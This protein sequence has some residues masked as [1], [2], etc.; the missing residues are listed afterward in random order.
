MEIQEIDCI[1]LPD[2]RLQL[3]WT[4]MV[5][6]QTIQV[7]IAKDS[8]FLQNTYS[9]LLPEESSGCILDVGKGIW[10]FRIGAWIGN[11]HSGTV[12]W[13]G[14]AG[15]VEIQSTKNSIVPKQSSYRIKKAKPIENGVRLFTNN[16]N[17]NY[18]FVEISENSGFP[19]SETKCVYMYDW[20]S[21]FFDIKPLLETL[22]YNI[23][24][25]PF[26]GYPKG[27]M[28][29]LPT[30]NKELNLKPLGPQKFADQ[31]TNT[32]QVQK[33]ADLRLLEEAKEKPNMR[34]S[35]QGDYLRYMAAR[36]TH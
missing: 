21:G 12:K 17:P 14:V 8:L 11:E 35:S 36:M 3:L 4:T 1:V 34:F 32:A 9:I 23:R 19:S 33:R 31:K 10:Y 24:Y 30:G 25:A 26:P 20:G 27:K 13:S 28:I 16:P 5:K 22:T 6:V 18:F 15:P 29:E 2:N 7:S